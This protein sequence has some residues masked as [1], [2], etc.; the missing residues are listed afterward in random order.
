MKLT[1]SILQ[2]PIETYVYFP[3]ISIE[4]LMKQAWKGYLRTCMRMT[5]EVEYSLLETYLNAML[6]I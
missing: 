4:Q 1:K 6:E 2:I 3:L 5:I